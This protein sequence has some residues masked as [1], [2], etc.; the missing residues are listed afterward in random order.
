MNR[1][2]LARASALFLTRSAQGKT[3]VPFT[4]QRFDYIT[5][6]I[7]IL[8]KLRGRM[9]EI[10]TRF[11]EEIPIIKLDTTH[12]EFSARIVCIMSSLYKVGGIQS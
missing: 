4:E 1:N 8:N 5:Q 11:S 2:L 10:L 12:Q 7:I 3:F 6:I 9:Q